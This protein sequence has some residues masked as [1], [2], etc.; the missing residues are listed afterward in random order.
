MRGGRE[1]DEIG[2]HHA[3][4][5][6]AVGDA[7]LAR[8]QPRRDR[9]RHDGADQRLGAL[10]RL[11]ELDLRAVDQSQRVK[12]H[13]RIDD[14]H[15]QHGLARDH[16][17]QPAVGRQQKPVDRREIDHEQQQRRDVDE[18]AGKQL[19][20][21][22]AEEEQHDAAEQEENMQVAGDAEHP[23][24]VGLS[25]AEEG[26]E[27]EAD[28]I[29]AEA[30][31]PRQHQ[32]QRDQQHVVQVEQQQAV[33]IVERRH[34][35]IRCAAD[36]ARI[37]RRVDA[38]LAPRDLRIARDD[39]GRQQS[40]EPS[41]HRQAALRLAPDQL[42]QS[43]HRPFRPVPVC[44]F[45]MSPRAVPD[46]TRNRHSRDGH[47]IAPGRASLGCGHRRGQWCSR[48]HPRRDHNDDD[49]EA[50]DR[51]DRGCCPRH[52]LVCGERRGRSPRWARWRT[53]RRFP[54]RLPRRREVHRRPA[55][56]PPLARP[57]PLP[58]RRVRL[59]LQHLLEV[60]AVR[61]RERLP[62]AALLSCV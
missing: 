60:H 44:P 30:V 39:P 17:A 45:S 28:D 32:A 13:R 23:D 5:L 55:L 38:A 24:D 54:W 1:A 57:P 16:V 51:R 50:D 52:R 2:E 59:R 21:P 22:D 42:A 27:R 35:D 48:S 4:G 31:Q 58:L 62:R 43:R 10:M 14:E 15:A 12:G 56:R 46:S 47:H 34:P 40:L 41:R 6:D 53:R 20:V 11:L 25:D 19:P 18:H 36:R 9:V 8:L 26:H 29:V 7:R 49:Q 3:Q 61:P 37:D 33:E